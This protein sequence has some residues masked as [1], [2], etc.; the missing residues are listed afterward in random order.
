MEGGKRREEQQSGIYSA[1]RSKEGKSFFVGSLT[2]WLDRR[3]WVFV[4][5]VK[6]LWAYLCRLWEALSGLERSLIWSDV[7]VWFLGG[8]LLSRGLK[9]AVLRVGS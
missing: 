8:G 2:F 7:A 9:D 4:P 5:A 6:A 3:A 1:E